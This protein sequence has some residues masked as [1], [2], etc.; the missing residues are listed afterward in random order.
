MKEGFSLVELLT[1]II[2]ISLLIV[3]IVYM[4][5]AVT[6]VRNVRAS[7]IAQTFRNIKNA[8][9]NY[10]QTERPVDPTTLRIDTLKGSYISHVPDHFDL[11]VV[12]TG[13]GIYSVSIVYSGKYIELERLEK[14]GLQGTMEDN[15]GAFVYTS[16][17]QKS[18]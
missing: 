18:W 4:T 10:F 16:T 9:E 3:V 1:F 12:S 13:S 17:V 5:P 14:A 15:T 6:A 8:V 2:V 7:Q 11:N